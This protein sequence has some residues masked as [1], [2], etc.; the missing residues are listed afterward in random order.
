MDLAVAVVGSLVGGTI[1]AIIG[2]LVTLRVQDRE[3]VHERK[4]AREARNQDRRATAYVELLETTFRF[5]LWV[6]RTHFV[7]NAS[8][9]TLDHPTT[10]GGCGR[11]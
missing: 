10:L 2:G 8:W 7:T 11:L 3:H 4:M 5:G 1:A 6:D 9:Q